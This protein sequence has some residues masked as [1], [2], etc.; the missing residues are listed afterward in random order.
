MDPGSRVQLTCTGAT[1]PVVVGG[2]K[3]T[4]TVEPSNVTDVAL[5]GQ[6]MFN[7]GGAGP[8]GVLEIGGVGGVGPVGDP[9]HA[10]S[11]STSS[12]G[13][14]RG[15]SFFTARRTTDLIKAGRC[16]S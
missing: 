7:G 12:P 4:A 10:E 11:R 8:V 15:R 13:M 1:P 2:A 3:G 9:L 6:L 5:P 16:V 14:R